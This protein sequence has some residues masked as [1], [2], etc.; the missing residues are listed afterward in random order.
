MSDTMRPT[1]GMPNA[2]LADM[3]DTHERNVDDFA[4]PTDLHR[5]RPDGLAGRRP[6]G[7][8]ER[9]ADALDATGRYVRNFD[10][11]DVMRDLTALAKAHPG[12]SLLTAMALGLLVG[13][14]MT[15]P[16]A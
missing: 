2:V 7:L 13:R 6:N 8:S 4:H 9:T 16:Q 5:D 1:P 15:R 3:P 10:S 11:R 12:T 14:V